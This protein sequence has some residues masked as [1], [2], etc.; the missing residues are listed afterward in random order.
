MDRFFPAGGGRLPIIRYLSKLLL[1]RVTFS[2][3]DALSGVLPEILNQLPHDA[4]YNPDPD[5]ADEVLQSWEALHSLNDN[6]IGKDMV[7]S[8][9]NC[10]QAVLLA[11]QAY[12]GIAA[13]G[14]PLDSKSNDNHV[15][16]F[17][18]AMDQFQQRAEL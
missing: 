7:S 3:K 8:L 14:I 17:L 13:S 10:R 5:R 2:E 4:D 9:E 12:S 15:L 1:N 6:L 11:E 16:P 18:E